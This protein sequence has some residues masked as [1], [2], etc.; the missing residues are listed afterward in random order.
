M[1]VRASA[2]RSILLIHQLLFSAIIFFVGYMKKIAKRKIMLLLGDTK[3]I[4]AQLRRNP[5]RVFLWIF[6]HFVSTQHKYEA[7]FS[8]GSYGG[9]R[10]IVKTAEQTGEWPP[11]RILE[12]VMGWNGPTYQEKIRLV[13]ALLKG[14]NSSKAGYLYTLFITNCLGQSTIIDDLEMLAH[15]TGNIPAPIAIEVGLKKYLMR[16]GVSGW[17]EAE[18]IS[19]IESKFGV[20]I[21]QKVFDEVYAYFATKFPSAFYYSAIIHTFKHSGYPPGKEFLNNAIARISSEGVLVQR[22]EDVYSHCVESPRL[23]GQFRRL[24]RGEPVD[25]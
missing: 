6:R 3:T 1:G 13:K 25:I 15:A 8:Q 23:L 14:A 2:A 18:T 9:A 16:A 17:V 21:G 22:E 11:E 10:G 20:A 5:G 4:G 7:F 19:K 24:A 12:W